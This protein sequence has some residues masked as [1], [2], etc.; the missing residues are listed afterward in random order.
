MPLLSQFLGHELGLEQCRRTC[1]HH[2]RLRT[3]NLAL[4][5]EL[6]V[7]VFERHLCRHGVAQGD[8][9][10]GGMEVP[11]DAEEHERSR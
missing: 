8:S 1:H 6:K 2:G 5:R 4:A 9:T 7:L 10:P 3:H 11:G